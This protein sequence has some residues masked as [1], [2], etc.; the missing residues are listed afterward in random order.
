VIRGME[1]HHS[2]ELVRDTFSRYC[3]R[4]EI[5]DQALV[6]EGWGHRELMLSTR[7]ISSSVPLWSQPALFLP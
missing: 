6:V 4:K 1:V 5:S 2:E 3:C 7:Y